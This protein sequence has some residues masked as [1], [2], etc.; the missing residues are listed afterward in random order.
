MGKFPV[1]VPKAKVLKTPG[2]L[3]FQIVREGAHISM[4]RQNTLT[5]AEHR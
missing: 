4:V 5:E 1:D 3:G 2:R